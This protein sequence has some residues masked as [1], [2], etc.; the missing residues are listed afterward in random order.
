MPCERRTRIKRVR[1]KENFYEKRSIE[2][3]RFTR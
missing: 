1:G 2:R 3:I